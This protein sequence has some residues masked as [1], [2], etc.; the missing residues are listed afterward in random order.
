MNNE[1]TNS[2]AESYAQVIAK[3]AELGAFA[4]S[5]NIISVFNLVFAE[6]ASSDLSPTRKE[7]S[8]QTLRRIVDLYAEK[9]EE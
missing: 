2:L 6:I 9:I 8:L 3:S 4:E 7:A 5:K 1:T